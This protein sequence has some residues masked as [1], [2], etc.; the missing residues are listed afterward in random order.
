M[1][2]LVFLP[3]IL[4]LPL[5][6]FS[7]V[8][9][10]AFDRLRDGRLRSLLLLVWTLP[11]AALLSASDTAPPA[12]LVAWAMLTALFYAWRAVV[13]Q[14]ARLW[15]VFLAVSSGALL[16]AGAGGAAMIAK[17]LGLS[18]PIAF[19]SAL[20]EIIERRQGA[21]HVALDLRLAGRAPKLAGLFFI[22]LLAVAAMPVSPSFFV[23]LA[24]VSNQAAT[25]V[26]T[27]LAILACWLLWSWAAARLVAGLIIGRAQ[28]PSNDIS[29]QLATACGAG[30]AG[31]GLV[32]VLLGGIML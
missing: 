26:M 18:L 30:V 20:I 17:A 9:V 21:A 12:W 32:G 27:T 28:A 14:D 11:G 13:L 7:M 3:A 16:W 6:P 4:L 1:S 25:S 15:I 5:F 10:L 19:A 8:A 22:G 24:L 23:L 31:L 2:V 29:G